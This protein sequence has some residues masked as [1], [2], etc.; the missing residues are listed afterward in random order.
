MSGNCENEILQGLK[1]DLQVSSM[2]LDGFLTDLIREADE[3][4]Q[5]EGAVADECSAAYRGLVRMYAAHLYRNRR[6][7]GRY[8]ES[9]PMPRMIRWALNNYIFGRKARGEGNG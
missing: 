7:D 2:A 1:T 5:A 4:I 6:D 3:F 9:K 8:S